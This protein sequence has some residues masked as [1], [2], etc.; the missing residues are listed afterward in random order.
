MKSLRFNFAA[1]LGMTTALLISAC[2]GGGGGTT[3]PPPPATPTITSI[4]VTPNSAAI[5]T[6]VQFTAAVSGTGSFSN[7][8]TWSLAAPSGSSLSPGTLTTSG[9]YTTPYPAPPTV[10]VTATSTQDLSKSGSV[11]VT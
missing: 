10:T 1:W 11:M 6:Q 5:G 8:V 4:T 2:G 7:A 3:T 9:L